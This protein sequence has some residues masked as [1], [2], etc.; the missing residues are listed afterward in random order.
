MG[1]SKTRQISSL[2]P[3]EEVIFRVDPY[4]EGK[5]ENE[6]GTVVSV[7]HD[8]VSV[9]YLCGYKSFNDDIPFE[10]MIGVYDEDGVDL[11]IPGIKGPSAKLVYKKM[12]LVVVLANI[13]L[14]IIGALLLALLIA[15]CYRMSV[16]ACE[17]PVITGY[18]YLG[19]SR[20][21]GMDNV[22]HMDDMDYTFTVAKVGQG[23]R[24]LEDVAEDEIKEIIDNNPEVDNW[25]IITGLGINDYWNIDRYIEYYDNIDYAQV[26]IE[27]VNPVEKS[28]CDIYGYN[29]SDLSN[30][31]IMFNEKIKDTD[32]PFIDTYSS[33]IEKGFSTA[34]GVHYTS[35]TYQFIYDSINLYLN[36]YE[37]GIK[38][39]TF[40]KTYGR[41]IRYVSIPENLI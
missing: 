11:K 31:A 28:K 15:A 8:T 17:A 4:H 26:I 13:L 1:K 18:I 33:M 38:N 29:Y 32:Y 16:S 21:V 2:Q 24:W 19:D 34:D 5:K 41:G 9:S 14:G 7:N 27:S 6:M 30:G 22:I 25:V 20:F 3:G 39:G 37:E 40:R 23:L 36:T 12:R 10:D 35:D